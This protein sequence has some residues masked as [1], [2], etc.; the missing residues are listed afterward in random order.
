MQRLRW[1]KNKHLGLHINRQLHYNLQ[2]I[3]RYDGRF[4]YGEVLYLLRRYIANFEE[5]HGAIEMLDLRRLASPPRLPWESTIGNIINCSYDSVKLRVIREICLGLSVSISE[6]F[7]SP[8]F[9]EGN[10]DPQGSNAVMR[11]S[12]LF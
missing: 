1:G 3:S 11:R 12:L 5:P 2:Y 9:Q 7:D 6:F 4:I 10:L 8:P